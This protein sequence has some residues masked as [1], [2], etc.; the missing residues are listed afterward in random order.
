VSNWR[1]ELYTC[2]GGGKRI[3]DEWWC[4]VFGSNQVEPEPAALLEELQRLG[5]DEVTGKFRGDEHGWFSAQIAF[6]PSLPPLEIERYLSTEDD[7]RAELNTWAAW[8]ETLEENPHAT[9]LME[10]IIRTTQLFT[11]RQLFRL[12]PVVNPGHVNWTVSQFLAR[13]TDGVYQVDGAGFFAP[14]GTLLVRK[15]DDE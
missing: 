1:S 7:I 4:R 2:V 13:Q 8:L 5:Y 14:D 10:R 6:A 11:L 15:E 12:M 9:R 3:P